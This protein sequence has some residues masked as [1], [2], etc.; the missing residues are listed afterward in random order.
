[1]RHKKVA[2]SIVFV[3]FAV[4]ISMV[5]L[6]SASFSK[7]EKKS[8]VKVAQNQTSSQNSAAQSSSSNEANTSASSEDSKNEAAP[9]TATGEQAAQ[10]NSEEETGF[11]AANYEESDF[12]PGAT[13][14]SY[15]WDIIKLLIILG[16]MVGGFYYFFKFVTKK[17]SLNVDG[18]EIINTLA[19]VPAGQNKNIQVI[20][21][22]GKL[23]ILGVADGG[24][25]LITEIT[26]KDEIERIRLMASRSRP[27]AA[28][29]FSDFLKSKINT[30]VGKAVEK[31]GRK[32]SGGAA[33]TDSGEWKR[34]DDY[35]EKQNN[36]IRD[37]YKR[38]SD[39]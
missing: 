36:R 25:N 21:V 20:D 15:A 14:G 13:E 39:E 12:R 17:T 9:A 8:P 2:S 18:D 22:A 5:F 38:G 11:P 28:G 4:L 16:L 33:F 19:V 1:M 34:G 24:I 23:L 31:L 29:G 10:G 30:H 3:F 27:A 35:L 6:V 7:P 26:N 37:L 32:K